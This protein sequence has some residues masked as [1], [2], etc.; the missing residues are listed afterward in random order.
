MIHHKIIYKWNPLSI[1]EE[2]KITLDELC[3]KELKVPFIKVKNNNIILFQII[4][5]NLII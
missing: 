3:Y 4:F 5:K 2:N 1:E